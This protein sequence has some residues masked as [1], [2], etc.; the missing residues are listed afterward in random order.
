M[1]KLR[2]FIALLVGLFLAPSLVFADATI[3]TG[4]NIRTAGAD[5]G[6]TSTTAIGGARTGRVLEIDNRGSASVFEYPK[7]LSSTTGKTLADGTLIRTGAAR[8]TSITVSGLAT[9]AD[10]NVLIY[11][12]LSATGTPKFEITLATAKDTVHINIPGGAIFSTGI[13]A[14]SSTTTVH[15]ALTYDF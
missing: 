2:L 13:F 11:D 7:T 14:D 12:A 6:F 1:K 15:L 9:A 5:Q 8:V 3:T 4:R 10:S